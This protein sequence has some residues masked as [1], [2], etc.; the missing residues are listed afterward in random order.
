[1]PARARPSPSTAARP[2]DPAPGRCPRRRHDTAARTAHTDAAHARTLLLLPRRVHASARLAV[3][4]C[5]PRTARR[6]AARCPLPRS[7]PLAR[8]RR[9]TSPLRATTRP[10]DRRPAI[11]APPHVA[12]PA[13]GA[14][15]RPRS[16]C[17]RVQPPR[18]A[19]PSSIAATE[20]PPR[21][22]RQG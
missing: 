19:T 10:P 1:M 16:P 15:P 11:T 4:T 6:C 18:R 3:P 8:T 14:S 20:P 9:A 7:A 13:A 22:P 17:A 12:T 5:A 2:L 21:R